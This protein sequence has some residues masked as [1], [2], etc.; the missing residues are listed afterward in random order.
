MGTVKGHFFQAPAHESFE[1]LNED[2]KIGFPIFTSQEISSWGSG[3]QD[4]N[5]MKYMFL[6]VEKFMPGAEKLQGEF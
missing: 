1:S 3:L 5:S 2:C 4:N 6:W